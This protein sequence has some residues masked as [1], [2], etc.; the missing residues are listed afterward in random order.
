MT[1][2]V[3]IGRIRWL[4]ILQRIAIGYF[5]AAMCKIWL[6]HQ[7][8]RGAGYFRSYIWHWCIMFLLS[9]IYMV[10]LY[11]LYVPDWQFSASQSTSSPLLEGASKVNCS[12]R[13]DLG[14]ACNSSGMIDRADNVL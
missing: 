8:S 11:V 12:V 4:G 6:P 10:L 14:P 13:G 2:G 9:T 3:D 7:R 5:V 1:Y